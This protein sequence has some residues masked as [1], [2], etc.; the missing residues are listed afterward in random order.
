[1]PFSNHRRD[2]LFAAVNGG[3]FGLLAPFVVYNLDPSRLHLSPSLLT[4]S[5]V[6]FAFGAVS[7]IALAIVLSRRFRVVFQAAKFATIGAANTIIDFGVLNLLAIL[8]P[9]GDSD[10]L[11]MFYKSISFTVAVVNSYFWNKFW[12]FEKRDTS[13]AAGEFLQFIAI[14]VS[15]AVLNVLVATLVKNLLDTET[16]SVGIN[17]GAAAA[18]LS[19]LVWNFLGYKFIVFKK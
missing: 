17:I 4:F 9:V 18:S 2:F 3:L 6:F 1:M 13:R 14:S 8:W 16:V 7:A 19:V 11:F 12:T 10:F 15:G 5:T